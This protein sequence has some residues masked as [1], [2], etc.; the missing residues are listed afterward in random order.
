MDRELFE[1]TLKSFDLEEPTA[2]N[3][4][5]TAP[6]AI[7]TLIHPGDFVHFGITH[8]IPYG[9]CNELLRSF[10]GTD[11]QFTLS[12][13]GASSNVACLI[14]RH[15]VKKL[16]TSY[17]GDIYPAPGPN[18]IFDEAWKA[19]LEIEPW[20]V[21]TLTQRLIAGALG[22]GFFPT[23]S[24][25]GSS[26][27]EDN[28]Q[29]GLF[30]II[31]NPFDKEKPQAVIPPLQPDVALVHGWMADA[32]GNTVLPPPWS[33]S[34]WGALASKKVIVSVEH[35]VAPEII[36]HYNHLVKIPGTVVNAVCEIPF[37]CHPGGLSA[38]GLTNCLLLPPMPKIMIL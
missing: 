4:V 16:I 38:S 37:G 27:A 15:L 6:E 5:M 18:R 14:H 19:G 17:A 25:K 7:Q 13:M 26:L 1:N 23:N 8:G 29:Q 35:I 2:L 11:P 9:L 36:R 10:D 24:L 21:L 31:P 12:T 32:T 28:A 30:A 20:T 22:L 34:P 3:K 33:E